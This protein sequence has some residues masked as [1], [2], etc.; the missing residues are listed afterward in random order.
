MKGPLVKIK[1]LLPYLPEKDIKLGERFLEEKNI[2]S[3][4]ELVDSAFYLTKR[5]KQKK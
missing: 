4:K 2:D 1:E 3:L 5:I